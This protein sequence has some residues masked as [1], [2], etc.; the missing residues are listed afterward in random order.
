MIATNGG[1]GDA[2]ATHIFASRANLLHSADQ[3]RFFGTDAQPARLWQNGSQVEAATLVMDGRQHSLS[4][5]PEAKK[6][7]VHAIFANTRPQVDDGV[8]RTPTTP[9]N[10]THAQRPSP[11]AA[12]GK[13]MPQASRDAAD[14]RADAMDYNDVTREATFHGEVSFRDPAGDMTG[15]HGVAFLQAAPASARSVADDRDG[16]AEVGGRLERFVLIGDVHLLQPGRSGTGNQ[17]T[18]TAATERFTLTGTPGNQP[19]IHDAQQG[20]VTGT[21][22]VFST[23]DSSIVVSGAVSPRQ[24]ASAG[25]DKPAKGTRVHT[26]T[27]L[28]QP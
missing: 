4:A 15:D 12:S 2:A 18:Y 23:A 1:E 28:K 20:T 25:G 24:A 16:V 8:P 3:S 5:R 6:G 17:L 10:S 21:T 26:E 14:V 13:Q 27:D 7:F 9:T 11:A 19:R 22:L